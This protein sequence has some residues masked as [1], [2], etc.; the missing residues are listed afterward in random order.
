[1][2]PGDLVRAKNP[3]EQGMGL[4][5][6]FKWSGD[7]QYAEVMWFERKATNGDRVSSCSPK[8]LEVVK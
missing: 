5:M 6:G 4:F 2:K 1:M 8:L 7:Y 3:A